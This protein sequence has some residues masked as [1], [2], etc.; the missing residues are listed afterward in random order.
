MFYIKKDFFSLQELNFQIKIF[1]LV[2]YNCPLPMYQEKK[3]S[4]KM[5][6]LLYRLEGK[7]FF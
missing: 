3:N 7:K 1:I 6:I 5:H 4:M 2:Q